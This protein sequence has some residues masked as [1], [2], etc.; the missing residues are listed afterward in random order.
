METKL[1]KVLDSK[2]RIVVG[3][4]RKRAAQYAAH[5]SALNSKK[6][7]LCKRRKLDGYRMNYGPNFEKSLLKGYSNFMKTELPQRIMFYVNGDWKDFPQNI[8]TLVRKDFQVRKSYTE[9]ELNGNCFMLD[10]MHMVRVDMKTGLQQPIA[11]IDEAGNC[12]IPETFSGEDEIHY[13]CRHEYGK[14]QQLF[15]G[16]PYG[17]HDIKLQL[18]I[19][20][21]GVGHS[22]LEEC[23]GE[24]NAL[25]KHFLIGK[26]PASN[27]F[28]VEVE[29][30]NK[31]SDVKVDEAV[32]ENQQIEGNLISRI[33]SSHGSLDFDTVRDMFTSGMNSLISADII[34]V[35]RGSSA[36]MEARLELFQKQIEITS[37]YRADA[38][39]KYAWLA[40][41]KEALSSIMMYGLGHCRPSKVKPVYGIGV[42]LTAANF[43][44]PSVNYCD[45]D[46]NGVQHIVLC[47]VIMGNMELVHPGS[48][49][50][51]PSSENFD[52]GVDDLQ[53]PKHYIIWNMNMNTHIY[54]EYVVSFKVSSRVG[55]EGYLIGNESNYDISG[56]TT[57]QGQSQ[58]HSKL[59][60]HPVG[61]GNDSHPTPSLGRSLGKATTLGSSTL[62]VPKSPW[63][64]FPMLFAAISKKVPLKDMQLVDTQYELFRRKKIS[65]ADFVKKLRLIVGDTLLKS[66]ITHLQ[67][68]VRVQFGSI[69]VE[70][71]GF[72]EVICELRIPSI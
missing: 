46:E 44:Y 52:S 59:G 16:E 47:R 33:G 68:K 8:I 14:D 29:D 61:L 58:G 3:W 72:C 26:K 19:D 1:E 70:I 38:N 62:R 40:A 67:C 50:C 17:S 60:L 6:N 28:D 36:S 45:V 53:N 27:R 37:K 7:R 15:F 25:D 48:G 64:P 21:K 71:F 13:C 39:V 51:H 66:T 49:Q 30:S 2:S 10:F 31:M 11:W 12:F 57:C 34:E 23:S 65:R 63:M 20:I 41:S 32:G 54:P 9:V 69:S 24:S 56:V 4:K 43:S 35:Y 5:L 22:K 42:H 55:A 18:E